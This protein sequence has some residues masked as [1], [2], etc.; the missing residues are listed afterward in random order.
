MNIICQVCNKE[1]ITNYT[2]TLVC[3]YECSYV[4]TKWKEFMRRKIKKYKNKTEQ[5]VYS[6]MRKKYFNI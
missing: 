6:L 2:R 1:I 5:E 4:K 3:S